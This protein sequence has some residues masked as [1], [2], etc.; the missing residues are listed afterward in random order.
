[1]LDNIDDVLN[2]TIQ[3]YLKILSGYN[4]ANVEHYPYYNY[5]WH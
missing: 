5:Y 4:R 2:I 3:V 1:M